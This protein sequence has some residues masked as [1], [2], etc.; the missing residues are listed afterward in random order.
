KADVQ[1]LPDEYRAQVGSEDLDEET[2]TAQI[3]A[4]A[5]TI[6][7]N[8]TSATSLGK[9]EPMTDAVQ[10]S[11]NSLND[12]V[13]SDT[14]AKAELEEK[15]RK[16]LEY[17]AQSS[18]FFSDIASLESAVTTGISQLQAG[19]TSFNG[20]FTLPSKKDLAWTKTVNSQ[21]EE[22]EAYLEA[23][24]KVKK[25]KALK[26]KDVKAIER[27]QKKHPNVKLDKT[28]EEAQKVYRLKK[29]YKAVVAKVKDGKPLTAKDIKAIEAYQKAYP[30]AKLDADVLR[31]KK[32]ADFKRKVDQMDPQTFKK[33]Y[34]EVIQK[35]DSHDYMGLDAND[36]YVIE[37]Y[38]KIKNTPEYRAVPEPKV[39][40]KFKQSVDKLSL[41]E[42]KQKYDYLWYV[43]RPGSD[44]IERLFQSKKERAEEDYVIHRYYE[45]L[46]QMPVSERSPTFMQDYVAYVNQTGLNPFTGKKA[47]DDVM[48]M[49]KHYHTVQ[50]VSTFGLTLTGG[51]MDYVG[52]KSGVSAA[53]VSDD[54]GEVSNRVSLDNQKYSQWNK[55]AE[56]GLAPADRVKLM[57]WDYAPT[58]EFY[59]KNKS[60]YDNP[61][62]FN[63][64]DGSVV[65]PGTPESALGRVDGSMHTDGFLNGKYEEVTLPPGTVIDR[66]GSNGSGRYF[67]PAGSSFESRAL[68][69]FMQNQPH[70]K[71]VVLKPL[72]VKAGTIAPWFDEPGMGFQY[73]TDTDM[74]IDYLKDNKYIKAIK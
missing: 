35:Y 69:P 17:N 68:P 24:D 41:H 3:S 29:N 72:P 64:L 54:V 16:L 74:G 65:Y 50:A 70:T 55:Y 40:K 1:K 47:S 73:L 49:A 19:V 25:G 58:P 43:P 44:P 61:D 59:L 39:S 31:L 60:V 36:L 8:Q 26:A 53:A 37:R 18:G 23:V 5:T 30:K 22:R 4:Y 21:W 28:V 45:L 14:A 34:K 67:S 6:E 48:F 42:L 27:Y 66:Y 33:A 2:L 12:A 11:I 51:Y 32:L 13:A 38:K 7:A 62:Y 52:L 10:A 56:A 63:Q 9:T 15:L 57:D 46:E 71:Y 20:T